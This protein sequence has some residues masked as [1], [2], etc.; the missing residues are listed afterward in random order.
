MIENSTMDLPL[1]FIL[2][3]TGLLNSVAVQLVLG[4]CFP[5]AIMPCAFH[6]G[7]ELMHAKVHSF[8]LDVLEEVIHMDWFHG[9]YDW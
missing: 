4:C 3:N 7:L 2:T 8:V 1:V 5:D 6:V 9:L